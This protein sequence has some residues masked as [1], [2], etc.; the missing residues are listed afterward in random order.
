M[1]VRGLFEDPAVGQSIST[2]L[3]KIANDTAAKREGTVALAAIA[4]DPRS[5][6]A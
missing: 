6:E 3:Q 4:K 1:A 2:V 5:A